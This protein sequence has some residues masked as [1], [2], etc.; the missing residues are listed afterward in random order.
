MEVFIRVVFIVLIALSLIQ[1]LISFIFQG[2]PGFSTGLGVIGVL[3]SV[4]LIVISSISNAPVYVLV[5]SC[6]S[7]ACFVVSCIPNNTGLCF[8]SD[9][10]CAACC[11]VATLLVF[12]S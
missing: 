6:V 10:L 3:L 4:S 11:L 12:L 2:E 9:L 1:M 8:G 7:T 5:F